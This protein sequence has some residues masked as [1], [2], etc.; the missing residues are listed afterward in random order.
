[1]QCTVGKH[2]GPA[3]PEIIIAAKQLLHALRNTNFRT[4]ITFNELTKLLRM[5]YKKVITSV[6]LTNEKIV[7]PPGT[8]G[9]K[10]K[11]GTRKRKKKKVYSSGSA[12]LCLRPLVLM[13]GETM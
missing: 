6:T 1:M 8:M 7:G 4:K 13:P 3:V 5:K 9:Q 2:V 12:L 11:V 10:V